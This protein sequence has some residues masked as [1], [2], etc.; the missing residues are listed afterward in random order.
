LSKAALSLPA[1]PRSDSALPDSG[2][3]IEEASLRAW[4]ALTESDFDGWR[5]RFADGYTRRAN[6][7]TPLAPSRLELADKISTCER[8]YAERGLPAIFR[9]TPFAP[10]ALDGILESRGYT[11]G[12]QVEVR[13]RALRGAP[14]I[15]ASPARSFAPTAVRLGDLS[16]ERWLDVFSSLSGS[17][18]ANR[19]AHRRVLAA[20][21][22]RRRL[23]AL[24][25]D[26]R[27]V[28]CGMSV[29][30]DG[31]LGLFD[32]VTARDSRGRG[33]GSEILRRALRWGTRAGAEAAYLQ[34]LED[35]AV[36]GRLY[37]RA[38]FEVVYRYHYR[39]P[40]EGAR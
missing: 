20:V 15:S 17:S 24:T 10:A 7:I 37:Q 13:A 30:A 6:S 29:L 32:L 21:P 3:R 28:A 27:P 4:P 14:P 36:A 18:D 8:L 9:L 19:N 40:P 12:D 22:G 38:G 33:Y 11:L 31:L 1:E 16:L 2:R 35:N 34:V 26:E 5:L 39:E 25:A 23:L